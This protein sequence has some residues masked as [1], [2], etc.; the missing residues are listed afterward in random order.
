M[1]SPEP[2]NLL[3]IILEYEGKVIE[4]Q[5]RYRAALA[6]DPSY[7]PALDNLERTAQFRYTREG[8]NLGD[9]TNEE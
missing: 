7:R 9:E 4:A 8:M 3:G 2:Y 1:E 5:K 6:L